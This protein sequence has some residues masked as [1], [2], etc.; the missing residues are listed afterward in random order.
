MAYY[1]TPEGLFKKRLQNGKRAHAATAGGEELQ[2]T[3]AAP[4]AQGPQPAFDPGMVGYLAMAVSLIEGRKVGARE[5]V[6]MLARVFLRQQGMERLRRV[7]Y[8]VAQLNK[9]PP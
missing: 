3:V 8:V 7:D 6:E 5:I 1:R 2:A 4:A 9:D